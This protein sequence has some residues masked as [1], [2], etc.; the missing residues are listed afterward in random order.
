MYLSAFDCLQTDFF[1]YIVKKSV[2]VTVAGEWEIGVPL[3]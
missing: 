3:P 2:C 1:V